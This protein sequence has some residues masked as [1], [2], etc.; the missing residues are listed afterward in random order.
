MSQPRFHLP[1]PPAD[2]APTGFP[3]FAVLAPVI[4]A[5]VLFAILQTP[6]VLLFAIL[7]PVIAVASAIDQRIAKR[8]HTR[9]ELA[10][11]EAKSAKLRAVVSEFIAKRS[12]AEHDSHPEPRSLL[13]RD[14]RH[15]DRW[16]WQGGELQIA[17]GVGVVG[18]SLPIDEP[19]DLEGPA[20]ELFDQLQENY[21]GRRGPVVLDA[22]EGIGIF[23]SPV[24]AMAIARG[25]VVQLLESI[26][27]QDVTVVAPD[28]PAWAWIA[29]GAHTVLRSDA[30]DCQVVRVLTDA[31]DFTVATAKSSEHLPRECRI[32]LPA[33]AAD[34]AV[35]PYALAEHDAA[36]HARLLSQAAQAAGMH[37]AGDLPARVELEHLLANQR[38][39]AP[40][41]LRARFLASTEPVDV[42]L[43]T[44][45][46]HAVVGGTTGSG[47]SELLVSWVAALASAYSSSVLNVLLVDFKG[48]A[49]FAG[50]EDLRHCVG[51]M[52]DL[53]EAGALRAIE[54][55]KS[56]L[57]HRERVLAEAGV[58]S[59]EETDVLPRLVVV[60]DE[61][62]AMLQ[63]LPDLHGLFVDIA[64]RGRSLG[65][66]LILCTQRPA[67][68]VRDALMTNCGLR[69]CLRVN[70]EGD[71]HAVVGSGEAAKIPLAAR[72]RC[73]VQVSGKARVP[74]Q[75][76][77]AGKGCIAALVEA[78]K[79][80]PHP[81]LPYRPPLAAT[82]TPEQV[83]AK[84]RN[85][86]VVFAVADRPAQQR[87]DAV[88]WAPTDGSVVV[89]GGA[90][91]GKTSLAARLSEVPAAVFVNDV[92]ALWDVVDDPADAS[93]IVIDDLDLL[94]MQAGDDHAHDLVTGLARRMREGR[95]VGRAFVITARR[96]NGP[97]AS[98]QGLAERHI[99]MRMPTRQE[100]LLA[101]ASGAY[102][103]DLQPGGGW[104]VGERIQAV[105]PTAKP[106]PLAGRRVR[107]D[108]T[109][110]A[111]VA[112]RPDGL[113]IALE[114]TVG[115]G[116]VG[117]IMFGTPGQWEQAWGA[118]DAAAAD[119][120]IIALDVTDRQLRSL[121]RT[122]V[123]LPICQ[124]R[125]QWLIRDGRAVR[126]EL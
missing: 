72:G 109:R 61:F 52:T 34:P 9:H 104:L 116:Q 110:C 105:L 46:P 102:D 119:R 74:A 38:D 11:F 66:H 33:D 14:R 64:A 21:A 76:A 82:I 70:D 68:A 91:C 124:G 42:D 50:L 28:D 53:D 4:G 113:P 65:V 90:G 67:D 20:R 59:I 115:P 47:K 71:S 92:E 29:S 10:K 56:E 31:G 62:A 26:P 48:G 51:L 87:Q 39:G 55:L 93:V 83:T 100:H 16:R 17:V 40:G 86:G 25:V 122:A 85:G 2:P 77:I 98:L 101:D 15:P 54:S 107:H 121:W 5:L 19:T 111:I 57:R 123:Q 63:E 120:P 75:S 112:A 81:R 6:Y 84:A 60:V 58:R 99:V 117:D 43:V 12:R 32:R 80:G 126:L 79:A 41:T 96:A 3:V 88:Q 97:I 94:L 78:S 89:V 69:I 27:P 7:S 114:H 106:Q 95:S 18:G 35:L 73:I 49:S 103:P 24:A 23:G 45:G 22:R 118:L 36:A 44:D 8:R 108:F 30:D 37:K 13:G 125:G 1:A